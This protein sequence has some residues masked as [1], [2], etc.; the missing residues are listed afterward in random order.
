M[1]NIDDLHAIVERNYERRTKDLPH[2]KRIIMKEMGE[3]LTWYY[4]LPLMPVFQKTH[5]KPD[6]ATV[7]E[8]IKIKEFLIRNVSELHKL[9]MQSRGNISDDL[10]N[11]IALVEKLQTMK[12]EVFEGSDA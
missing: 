10:Q 7:S 4:S 6:R 2:V 11:H 3:F 9:A 5:T 1:K 8:I 12:S